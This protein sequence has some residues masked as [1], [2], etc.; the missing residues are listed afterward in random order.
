MVDPLPTD[1]SV[2]DVIVKAEVV[3]LSSPPDVIGSHAVAIK[4]QSAKSI[5]SLFIF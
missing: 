4:A 1:T 2:F 5:N 3:V